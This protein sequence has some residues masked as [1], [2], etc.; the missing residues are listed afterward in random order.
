MISYRS[1]D[2]EAKF[3]VD[4]E[5]LQSVLTAL[6]KDADIARPRKADKLFSRMAETGWALR[7][8]IEEV[9][10]LLD[11]RLAAYDFKI[12]ELSWAL[13]IQWETIYY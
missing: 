3:V 12:M 10:Y 5:T 7:S 6:N 2:T 8:D 4:Y 1:I 9:L 13:G 11:S